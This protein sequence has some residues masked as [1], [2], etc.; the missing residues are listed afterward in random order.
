[1]KEE[2]GNV[3]LRNFFKEPERFADLMNAALYDGLEFV[4]KD[5]LKRIDSKVSYDCLKRIDCEEVV[6]ED[7][8]HIYRMQ[9]ECG[10]LRNDLANSVLVNDM[11]RYIE[12]YVQHGYKADEQDFCLEETEELSFKLKS[13]VNLVICCCENESLFTLSPKVAY[14]KLPSFLQPQ[15]TIWK[16]NITNLANVN[17]RRLRTDVCELIQCVKYAMENELDIVKALDAFA[18]PTY[19]KVVLRT[20]D[21]EDNVIELGEKTLSLSRIRK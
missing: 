9:F 4:D 6:M 11:L 17:G 2:N 15:Y 12:Q 21:D 20:I 5:E 3:I 18:E 7:N 13:V 19:I 16:L 14:D 1:M 8:K 10:Q